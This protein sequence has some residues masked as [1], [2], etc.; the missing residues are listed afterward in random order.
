MLLRKSKVRNIQK[1]TVVLEPSFDSGVTV[2]C[3][4]RELD[5]CGDN[6]GVESSVIPEIKSEVLGHLLL[7]QSNKLRVTF[8][9]QGT[10]FLTSSATGDR[11]GEDSGG[12]PC[13]EKEKLVN[14][15]VFSESQAP[16]ST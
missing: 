8:C 15:V 5:A 9:I 6:E 12:E 4:T 11:I 16:S 14:R 2:K 1:K 10:V 3:N 13:G 7:L